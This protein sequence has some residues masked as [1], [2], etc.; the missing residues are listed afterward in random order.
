PAAVA[1][2]PCEP[3]SVA[4]RVAVKTPD[5]FVGPDCGL[6][7]FP[8]PPTVIETGAPAMAF[9]LASV[10]VT[11]MVA[12]LLPLLAVML[13]VETVSV[14]RDEDT[15]PALMLNRLLSAADRLGEVASRV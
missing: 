12:L 4:L 11:V 5:E 3:A 14:D 7:V 6:S 2:T 15:A 1:L 13:P 10:T 8:E 9:P